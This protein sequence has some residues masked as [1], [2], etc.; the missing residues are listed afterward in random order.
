MGK[1]G[2][3]VT[4]GG[5]T[6]H[7]VPKTDPGRPAQ[8][9]P[10]CLPPWGWASRHQPPCCPPAPS[11]G[12]AG[13]AFKVLSKL[14]PLTISYCP[15]PVNPTLQV[16]FTTCTHVYACTHPHTDT[17]ILIRGLSGRSPAMVNI[18]R[19]VCT[20]PTSPGSQAEGTGMRMCEQ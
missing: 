10:C 20:T 6:Q 2:A 7:K 11:S 9:A 5:L 17:H 4:P 14:P 16:V 12:L 1:D 15:P 3:S 19:T 18:Q 8:W 13:L